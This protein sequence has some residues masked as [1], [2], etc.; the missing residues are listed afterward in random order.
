MTKELNHGYKTEDFIEGLCEKV[1]LRDFTVR[2]PKYKKDGIEKEVSDILVLFNDTV[3]NFQVKSKIEKKEFSLKD[4]TDKN[5][6]FKKVE[7][8]I[9]QFKTLNRAEKTNS[10]NE[11]LTTQ[12]ITIPYNS[13]IIAKKI[14]IVCLNLE[15]ENLLPPHERTDLT[16]SFQKKH[17]HEIHSF[18]KEVLEAIFQELDTIPDFLR[19]L[20]IRKKIIENKIISPLPSEL[21]FLGMYK[22]NWPD[23]EA[24]INQ[25]ENKTLHF[26]LKPNMWNWYQ[27]QKQQ[28][29]QRNKDNEISYLV[30]NCIETI[31]QSIGFNAGNNVPKG[32]VENYLMVISCLSKL[33]RLERRSAGNILMEKTVKAITSPRGFNYNYSFYPDKSLGIFILGFRGNNRKK[34]TDILQKYM[35]AASLHYNDKGL[36]EIVG[37]ATEE[38]NRRDRSYDVAIFKDFEKKLCENYIEMKKEASKLFKPIKNELIEEFREI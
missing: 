10:F 20:E 14:G 30:D 7:E 11:L 8:A 21:D 15:G 34:R 38:A 6:I 16:M 37:I 3:I 19:Y 26:V 17:N 5:R 35:H 22:G 25:A 13:Q 2:S 1:C 12:G 29:N 9:K 18:M 27:N 31:Y 28:I 32:T 24:G 23:L 33:N 36:K 4:E